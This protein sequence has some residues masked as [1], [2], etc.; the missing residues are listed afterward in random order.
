MFFL[1]P[2]PGDAGHAIPV[3]GTFF[4]AGMSEKWRVDLRMLKS[5]SNVR[6]LLRSNTRTAVVVLV[7]SATLRQAE[8]LIESCEHCNE[9]GTQI[10]SDNILDR[11][12]GS[13]PTVTDYR[14]GTR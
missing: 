7:Q 12:T 11:V 13:D 10:P 6:R 3:L 2:E 5:D 1:E 8:P 4:V 14:I 9:E